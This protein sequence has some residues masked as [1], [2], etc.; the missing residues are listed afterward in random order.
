MGKKSQTVSVGGH[1]LKITNLDKVLYPATGTTKADVLEYYARVARV[2]I[3][4]AHDRPATRKRWVNGVGTMKEPG[5]V[6][7]QKDLDDSTPEWVERHAIEHKDHSN[8]YP[9]VNNAATLAWLAQIAALEI[10]VPQW[11]FDGRGLA[12]N[13]DRLVLDLDPG[14]G[15]GLAECAEVA[16]AAKIIFDDM[17]LRAFPVT[18]GSKGIH[19]YAAL[20]GKSTSVQVSAVARELARALETEHPELVVSD[21]KRALRPGKVFVDW[22][23]NNA[24]KTT[25]APYSLRGRLRPTVAAPRTWKEL[26]SAGLKHLEFEEVLRRVEKGNDPLAEL[27]D[28]MPGENA[29]TGEKLAAYISMRDPKRTPEPMSGSNDSSGTSFVIQEHHA[30]QLHYDFRLERDGVLVSWALPKGVPTSSA[31]NHLAVQTEDHPL[32]YGSFEGTIPAG[33]YGAGTVTI[34]DAG[35]YEREKWRDDEVI[36]TLHGRNGGG[37]GVPTRV[38]LI[39]TGGEGKKR[40]NWLIHLMK[41]VPATGQSVSKDSVAS[42]AKAT[43]PKGKRH[44]AGFVEPM[45]ATLGT[46]RDISD[47]DEWAFEMK[48]DG[49]RIIAAVQDDEAR[50]FTRNRRD[51][52]STFPDVAIDI[53][54]SSRLSSAVFDGEIVAL[55]RNGRPDFG[56][57]QQRIG[58]TRVRDVQKAMSTVPVKYFLFDMI[59]SDGESMVD[60]SY[61]SRRARLRE[62]VV[63][64][65]VVQMPPAFDVGLNTAIS[66]SRELELEGVIAKR[67]DDAYRP[68]R[69]SR[70][71]I[72]IKHHRAQ[73]VVVG[74]WRPGKGQR[75]ATIGSLLVGVP[76]PQGLTYVGRVGTGFSER[77]LEKIALRLTSR[78]RKTSPFVDVPKSDSA[79]A[80][81]VRPDLVGE[82][83]F[84]EWTATGRLRQPSWRGWRPDK[85]PSDVTKEQP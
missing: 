26:E 16:R 22:S 80:H 58:L 65:D 1:R 83:Q 51:V 2:F 24:A 47:E 32:D 57:L 63:E 38:A 50:L 61:E 71:W 18:S 28:E 15:I 64:S 27:V 84:V 75:S 74:G 19:L 66:A 59:E 43:K 29:G 70:G 53:A 34:W 13:P 54:R 7:F 14:D 78:A 20:D 46:E 42:T 8:H 68:G 56:L 85:S 45:L 4:Y 21:M 3:R 37:L 35:E 11:K 81:W 23:Q 5:K 33:Q 60:D 30:R 40:N 79:D 72:K 69:R 12:Q 48:W 76:G 9:L 44:S 25:V 73:E 49:M 36:V 17:G 55:N 82:V 39:R 52:T 6:F 10:H 77:E 31:K 62:A 67:L 41:P